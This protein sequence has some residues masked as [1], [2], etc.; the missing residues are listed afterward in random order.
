MWYG[1]FQADPWKPFLQSLRPRPSWL[2][3]DVAKGD[4]SLPKSV[5]SLGPVPLAK[6]CWKWPFQVRRT[7]V[8]L[9]G[10]LWISPRPPV[11]ASDVST[12]KL[13]MPFSL[14]NPSERLGLCEISTPVAMMFSTED[15]N[16]VT[17]CF[18]ASRAN[19]LP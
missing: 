17:L 12:Y 2:N 11:F 9:A 14:V 13:L 18:L 15:E 8:T 5:I 16:C 3:L 6:L 7:V 4:A 1:L 10:T 19:A